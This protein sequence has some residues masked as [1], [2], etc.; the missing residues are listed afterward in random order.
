MQRDKKIRRSRFK[1]RNSRQISPWSTFSKSLWIRIF[2][3][4]SRTR[5]WSADSHSAVRIRRLSASF[6]NPFVQI[7][8]PKPR[9]YHPLLVHRFGS[10]YKPHPSLTK[11]DLVLRHRFLVYYRWLCYVI[12]TIRTG[13]PK[14]L[15]NVVSNDWC[16]GGVCTGTR[17]EHFGEV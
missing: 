1:C 17:R 10:S 6:Y 9:H 15:P 8:L 5:T 2:P 16:L 13:S 3:R 12:C 14:R 7:P 11:Q 4:K